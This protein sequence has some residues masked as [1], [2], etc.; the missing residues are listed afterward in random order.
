M[1]FGRGQRPSVRRLCLAVGENEGSS[2]R[3]MTSSSFLKPP[4]TREEARLPYFVG[5]Q[6]PRGA[7]GG[8][9]GIGDADMSETGDKGP[10]LLDGR[11]T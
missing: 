9:P 3:P 4:E 8:W 11:G 2:G 5:N 10:A 7:L 1:P 6:G